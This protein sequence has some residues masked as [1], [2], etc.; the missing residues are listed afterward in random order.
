MALQFPGIVLL[1]PLGNL[2]LVFFPSSELPMII[3]EQPDALAK[4]PL[5]P[6]FASQFETMVPSGSELTGK[7]F[8]TDSAAKYY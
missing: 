8:P 1:V 5:S 7:I 3:V 2:I 6:V 4:E